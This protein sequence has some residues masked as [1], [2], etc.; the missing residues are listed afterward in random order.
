MFYLLSTTFSPAA[1]IDAVA[2]VLL[3][4]LSLI[5]VTLLDS[6]FIGIMQ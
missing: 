6:H 3:C 5:S 2:K 4:I 1:L